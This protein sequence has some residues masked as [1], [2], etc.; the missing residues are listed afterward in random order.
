MEAI[1]GRLQKKL[2]ELLVEVTAV[3]TELHGIDEGATTP[4]FDQIELPA[5]EVGQQV[6]R[7]IQ[8][9]RACEVAARQPA[10]A[11]CPRCGRP[12]RVETEKRAVQSA[13]GPLEL[14]ETIAECRP[15]RRS[16]FPAA[17]SAGI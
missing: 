10:E 16:F 3:A 15:C 13:D 11:A 17:G 1:R 2:D 14:L 9:Q 5:H 12:C 7:M 6:S 8:N 4:H